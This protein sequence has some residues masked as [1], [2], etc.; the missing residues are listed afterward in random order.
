VIPR[1]PQA[2]TIIE[3]AHRVTSGVSRLLVVGPVVGALRAYPRGHQVRLGSTLCLVFMILEVLVGTGLV[4]SE[5]VA[6]NGSMARAA[7]LALHLDNTF[8]F[9]AALA[10]TAWWAA[11]GRGDGSGCVSLRCRERCASA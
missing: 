2:E 11:G 9:L 5:S 4:I 3:F 10:L 8:L 7:V 1:S 6:G